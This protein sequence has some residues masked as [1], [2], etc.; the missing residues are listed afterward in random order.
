MKRWLTK[1]LLVVTSLVLALALCEAGLWLL[2][3]EYPNF[4]E[5]DPVLGSKLRPG[6]E[7]YFL[8]EGGAYVRINSDGL[9]DREHS[10]A[11][12]P[13]T[14]R[15]AVL[16]DSFPE[17]LHVNRE[18]AFWAVMERGLQDCAALGDRRV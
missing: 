14:L 11:K 15:I 1:T 17:A 4:Y 6:V 8:K 16:G 7:G 18:E 10:L 5:Y 12:P 9:R 13:G 3:I 2:G